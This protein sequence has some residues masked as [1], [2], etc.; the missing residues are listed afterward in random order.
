MTSRPSSWAPATT[1]PA[2]PSSATTQSITQEEADALEAISK[3][4]Y[5]RGLPPDPDKETGTWDKF[6]GQFGYTD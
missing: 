1:A 2:P 6:R 3:K 4:G 5:T